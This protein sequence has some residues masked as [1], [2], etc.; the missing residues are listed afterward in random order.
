MITFLYFYE[1]LSIFYILRPYWGHLDLVVILVLVCSEWQYWTEIIANLNTAFEFTALWLKSSL[2]QLETPP[3]PPALDEGG[4]ARERSPG[5]GLVVHHQLGPVEADHG[6]VAVL[7][8]GL[9]EAGVAS[10][11]GYGGAGRGLGDG[12]LLLPGLPEG[13][14]HIGVVIDKGVRVGAT[15]VLFTLSAL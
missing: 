15:A 3:P 9:R 4:E 8:R 13:V 10:S 2:S 5:P 1:L 11:C 7:V 12:L 6:A 14:V